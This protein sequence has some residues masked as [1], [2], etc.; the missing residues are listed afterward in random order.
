MILS[1][2]ASVQ[3]PHCCIMLCNNTPTEAGH[4]RCERKGESLCVLRQCDGCSL[5][6]CLCCCTSSHTRKHRVDRLEGSV[7]NASL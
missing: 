6:V 1:L 4:E 7:L 2:A 3:W 5:R